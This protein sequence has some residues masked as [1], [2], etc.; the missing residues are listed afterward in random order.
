MSVR[1]LITV[2]P[3]VR[4]GEVFTVSSTIRHAMETGYRR[5]AEGAMMPRDLIRRF[6]AHY[7]V[8]GS[9]KLIFAADLFAAIAA[10]PYLAFAMRADSSGILVL[11]WA[12]DGGF[13]HV[14]RAPIEVA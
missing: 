5:S 13:Q 6:T 14:E 2:P 1:T 4:R 9:S 12:G 11:M 8:A 3:Q 7:E 10:N